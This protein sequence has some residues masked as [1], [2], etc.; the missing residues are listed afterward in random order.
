MR[1]LARVRTMCTMPGHLRYGR[2]ERFSAATLGVHQ[3]VATDGTGAQRPVERAA[4]RCE[5]AAASCGELHQ[6]V[7]TAA[8]MRGRHGARPG[9]QSPAP[10]RRASA[11]HRHLYLHASDCAHNHLLSPRRRHLP[12]S[13]RALKGG[14]PET[15][16][17]ISEALRR[18]RTRREG[19]AS[20]GRDSATDDDVGG[21]HPHCPPAVEPHQPLRLLLLS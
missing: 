9:R 3:L 4:A 7:G 8:G 18:A 1:V 5:W 11:H 17:D 19:R 6:G 14:N 10:A 21:G 12:R 20:R 2:G 13:P 15:L 16:A